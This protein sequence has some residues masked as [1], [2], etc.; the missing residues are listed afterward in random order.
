M[1]VN[2]KE[3]TIFPNWQSANKSGF[4]LICYKGEK[5]VVK[6]FKDGQWALCGVDTLEELNKYVDYRHL[7]SI[8]RQSQKETN[9]FAEDRFNDCE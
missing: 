7:Q 2:E 9:K 8:L 6:L 4:H 5:I 3:N 1:T